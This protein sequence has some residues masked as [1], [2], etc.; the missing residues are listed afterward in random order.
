M[1]IE[2][3]FPGDAGLLPGIGLAELAGDGD[4]LIT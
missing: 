1:A 2:S 4:N 3:Q